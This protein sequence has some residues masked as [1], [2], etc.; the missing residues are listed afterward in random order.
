MKEEVKAERKP[1]AD[2]TLKV[3]TATIEG[4]KHWAQYKNTAPMLFQLVGKQTIVLD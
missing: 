3:I 2:R 4:M 1:D